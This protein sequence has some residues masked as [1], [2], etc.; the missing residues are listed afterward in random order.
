MLRWLNTIA[1][2]STLI[3][4]NTSTLIAQ[5]ICPVGATDETL[6]AKKLQGK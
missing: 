3:E 6:N 2:T 5:L 1:N 4:Y